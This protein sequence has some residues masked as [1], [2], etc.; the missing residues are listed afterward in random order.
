MNRPYYL[1]LLLAALA[2]APCFALPDTTA[3]ANGDSSSSVNAS[4]RARIVATIRG[5]TG[6][7]NVQGDKVELKD[8]T[9]YVNGRS[10]GTVPMTCE[11]KYIIT[12][13]T[14][15]L[16]VDGK[17]RSVPATNSLAIPGS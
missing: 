17:A 9:V 10:F 14:R 13:D 11:I 15:T 8:R 3:I 6:I 7:A 4:D 12:K 2:S 16:F 5:S 1:L